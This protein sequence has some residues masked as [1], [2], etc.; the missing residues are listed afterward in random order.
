MKVTKR[1]NVTTIRP[2]REDYSTDIEIQPIPVIRSYQE[3]AYY[4]HTFTDV[5]PGSTVSHETEVFDYSHFITNMFISASANVYL[6]GVIYTYQIETSEWLSLIHFAGYQLIKKR[7]EVT[8]PVSRMKI[9]VTNYGDV[10]I[11]ITYSHIGLKGIEK[12]FPWYEPTVE[13]GGIP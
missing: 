3:P 6:E 13:W 1:F 12:I 4:N 7:I 11:D 8:V 2:G 9:E 5:A 10:P